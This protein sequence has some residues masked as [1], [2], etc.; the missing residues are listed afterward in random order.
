MARL[1]YKIDFLRQQVTRKSETVECDMAQIDPAHTKFYALK[2]GD[3]S[4][5]DLVA[6]FPSNII[7]AVVKVEGK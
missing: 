6:S 2:A 1:K 3:N 5:H 7:E 4:G